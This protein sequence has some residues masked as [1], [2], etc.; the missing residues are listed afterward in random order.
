[1]RE[2]IVKLL[3]TFFYSG[4]SPLVPGTAGSGFALVLYL[5]IRGNPLLFVA[6]TL[7]VT[8][9]GFLTA[10]RA[11]R[12]FN[13]KDDKRIVIDEAGGM[14]LTFMGLPFLGTSF[15]FRFALP[16]LPEIN[17]FLISGFVVFRLIDWLKP[18][19]LRRLENLPGSYG[20]MLDD[21]G[22]AVYANLIL[23]L[24]LLICG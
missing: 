6:V 8:G 16:V 23:R 1:M 15:L 13:K 14:L 3:A 17:L 20:V 22:A 11:E 12:I 18:Y 7:A 4:Y 2:K 10:H 5:L 24:L 19:P 9:F 21:L